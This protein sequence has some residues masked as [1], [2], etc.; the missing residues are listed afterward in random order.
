LFRFDELYLVLVDRDRRVLDFRLHERERRRMPAM[1]RPIDAGLFG[2]LAARAE[3]LVVK[4][5]RDAPPEL[6]QR[7]DAAAIPVGSLLAVPLVNDGI[8]LGLLCV[9][10]TQPGIYGDADLNL[11]RQL[12]EQVAGALADARAFEDLETYRRDLE[13]RVA[14]R[15][16]ELEKAS[17]EKERLITMLRER[18]LLLERESQEDVLTGIANRR[19]FVQRLAAEIE[20]SLA[21]GQ[22]LSVAIVDL[23]N[24]K[25]VNDQLGHPVGDRALRQ[26]AAVMRRNCRSSD[27][28]ARIG[29]EEFALILPGMNRED[30]A[31]FCE[32][33]RA[34]VATHDWREIDAALAITVSVGVA[35][36]DGTSEIDELVHHADTQL[37]RAKRAGRNQ[38][39]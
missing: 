3:P 38:V 26:T 21:V 19:C 20:V 28:V 16:T 17:V 24:F 9:R 1:V 30:A 10:H 4:D 8:V 39:A 37:Y 34:A 25:V 35:Q 29:G 6:V 22:P 7:V 33:L 31:R 23:D 13:E 5:W 15:T 11:I 12:G 18:S 2:W 36:W 27:L 32:S 14:E